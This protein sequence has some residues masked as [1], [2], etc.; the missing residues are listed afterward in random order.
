MRLILDTLYGMEAHEL[1]AANVICYIYS[2]AITA[3]ALRWILLRQLNLM[4]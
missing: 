2:N 1:H 4:L 3:N